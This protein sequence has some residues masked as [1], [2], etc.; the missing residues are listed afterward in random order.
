MRLAHE[1]LRLEERTTQT[2]YVLAEHYEPNLRSVWG[3]VQG[4]TRLSQSTPYQDER[5][6]L[7]RA[8][9]RLLATLQ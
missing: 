2:A 9:S 8:A 3:C 6:T 4:L 1:R 5:F 7:D